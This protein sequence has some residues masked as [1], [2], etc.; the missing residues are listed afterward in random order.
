MS[1]AGLNLA[2]PCP[3]QIGR[4]QQ[5]AARAPRIRVRAS[6]LTQQPHLVLIFYSLRL[7][8]KVPASPRNPEGCCCAAHVQV[9]GAL[10]LKVFREWSGIEARA[11]ARS[12]SHL[13]ATARI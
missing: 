1:R 9:P 6:P 5:S 7:A 10:A 13:L 2:R 4:C 3:L 12:T 8:K 11:P